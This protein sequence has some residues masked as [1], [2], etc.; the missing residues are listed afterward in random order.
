MFAKLGT[1]NT[2]DL[3]QLLET[4][5]PLVALFFLFGESFTLQSIAKG[6][7]VFSMATGGSGSIQCPDIILH[8]GKMAG[9]DCSPQTMI[10]FKRIRLVW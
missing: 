7:H 3:H 6:V 10:V 9:R 2:G 8:A 5:R 4:P 1:P